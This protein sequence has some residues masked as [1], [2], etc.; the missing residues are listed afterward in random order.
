MSKSM[1][2][3]LALNGY[4]W[5]YRQCLKS[6]Q[7]YAA[8]LG[9]EYEAVHRPSL[10]RLGGEVAWLKLYLIRAALLAGYQHVLFIDADAEVS[11]FAPDFRQLLKND[12][13]IYAAN[14][15]SG[16]INSGVL[17]FK[18]SPAAL[19][20]LNTIIAEKNRPIPDDDNVGWGENGHV[21]HF[22]RSFDE[23]ELLDSRWNNNHDIT[24]RDFI[25]HY[26]AGPIRHYFKPSLLEQMMFKAIQYAVNS[27][28]KITLQRHSDNVMFNR[29]LDATLNHYPQFTHS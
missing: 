16:R 22:L 5:R 4:H 26:S 17:L 1:I 9:I 27:Y 21:I 18:N 14:G 23:F 3:S 13:S 12:K 7:Q 28:K 19:E 20:W 6:Q 11:Q 25:R 2:F 29:I 15:Y 24:L 10:S 8:R